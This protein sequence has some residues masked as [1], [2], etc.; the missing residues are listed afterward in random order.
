MRRLAIPA[1]FAALLAIASPLTS[2]SAFA[3]SREEGARVDVT[4]SLS[5]F[6]TPSKYWQNPCDE[7]GQFS[8]YAAHETYIEY[9]LD[10]ATDVQI[11]NGGFG[12]GHGEE[13]IA[14]YGDDVFSTFVNTHTRYT[15]YCY[16]PKTDDVDP[17]SIDNFW[18]PLVTQETVVAALWKHVWDYVDAP[19]IR[20]PSMDH[21]FG[22]L[23]VQTPMDFRVQG[24][25]E[26]ALAATVTNV[27]GTVTATIDARPTDLLLEPGEPGGLPTSCPIAE[28]A[29]P[30]SASTPG[31]CSITFQNSS[32]ISPS[33]TFEANASVSWSIETSDPGF[34]V[35]VI[36]T[37]SWFDI[38]VAD[39]QAVVTG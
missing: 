26:V 13:L 32:A 38:A 28:S 19:T 7:E 14:T 2:G 1:M 11:S 12:A 16:D 3:G 9:Y 36:R 18:V 33:G 35:S 27:T 17:A 24:L 6:E 23:Y 22:W 10:A 39:A 31:L 25:S 5:G 37:W 8:E 29:A 15:R 20:W 21:N 34:G 4:V 30:Y